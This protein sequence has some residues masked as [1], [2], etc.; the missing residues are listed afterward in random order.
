MPQV[1]KLMNSGR[2]WSFWCTAS[3]IFFGWHVVLWTFETTRPSV[4]WLIPVAHDD[5]P[6]APGDPGPIWRNH[7]MSMVDSQWPRYRG[8]LI[9]AGWWFGCHLDYFPINIGL[10][11]SS[12][13]TNIFQRGGPTTNQI[14]FATLQG[15]QYGGFS[16]WGCPKLWTVYKGKW[17]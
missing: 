14:G 4:F 12:Q 2:G 7:P 11:S 13:L 5:Q 8:W 17:N 10:H 1:S 16:E 9:I 3:R 15:W 6:G